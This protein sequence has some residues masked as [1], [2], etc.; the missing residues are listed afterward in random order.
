V[1]EDEIGQFE[2]CICYLMCHEPITLDFDQIAE[3][4]RVSFPKV[5]G[6]LRPFDLP[7]LD[8]SGIGLSFGGSAFAVI[9][10]PAK[11]PRSDWERGARANL[12]WPEAFVALSDHSSHIIIS[13]V[14]AASSHKDAVGKAVLT[15]LLGGAI[16]V[17]VE[18][19]AVCWSPAHS[20]VS[21]ENFAAM[22][23]AMLADNVLGTLP[24]DSWMAMDFGRAGE[25][26]AVKSRG[27]SAFL[28]LEL[29]LVEDAPNPARQGAILYDVAGHLIREGLVFKDG[30]TVETAQG[31]FI[32]RVEADVPVLRLEPKGGR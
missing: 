22:A 20:V 30:A 12:A 1:S 26:Y 4:V 15:T 8:E 14:P 31:L 19:Q 18:A 10:V 29:F 3:A 7:G 25:R 9:A 32:A 23:Q 21:S 11:L 16:A 24:L 6:S 2:R 28:G 27:L 5:A 17:A 13:P